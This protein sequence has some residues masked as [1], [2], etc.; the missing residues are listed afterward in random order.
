[1]R[2]TSRIQPGWRN[3]RRSHAS[4]NQSR[5]RDRV[6]TKPW[7]VIYDRTCICSFAWYRVTVKYR[8]DAPLSRISSWIHR[9][10][11]GRQAGR[12]RGSMFG[13]WSRGRDV[14]VSDGTERRYPSSFNRPHFVRRRWS[15]P[16]SRRFKPVAFELSCCKLLESRT[17][18]ICMDDWGLVFSLVESKETERNG[19]CRT[20]R[21]FVIVWIVC[22]DNATV[23]FMKFVAA[24]CCRRNR[25]RSD[26]RSGYVSQTREFCARWNAFQLFLA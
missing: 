10:E 7:L 22:D 9:T 8:Y 13:W 24:N 26:S 4:Q 20:N 11:R 14:F 23:D 2:S 25:N 17:I 3:F 16:L 6:R 21:A 12:E 1:M 5:T 18:G 15:S 19:F